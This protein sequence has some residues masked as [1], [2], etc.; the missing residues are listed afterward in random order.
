MK[1]S[2]FLAVG[3]IVTASAIITTPV[4]IAEQYWS[5][6]SY[7]LLSGSDYELGDTDKT[8]FTVEHASGQSWGSTFLFFDRL[9][10]SN[11]GGHETYGEVGFNFTITKFD[12]SFFKD[13]YAA[14]QAELNNFGTNLLYGVG[15]SLN[16]PGAKYF[17]VTLYQRN[18][19]GAGVEDSNQITLTWNFPFADGVV[20][21]DGFLDR[22]SSIGNGETSTNLTSQLKFDLG[23]TAFGLKP[24]K[25]FVGIEHVEWV[26]KFGTTTDESNTNLLLKVHM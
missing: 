20:V 1:I 7:T 6:T 5:D 8:V 16:V 9:E 10:D 25:L 15:T 3:A 18:N 23:Q 14:T 19:A 22:A 24:G 13:V 11:N 4:A 17:T 26:N 2:K 21:Y 12:D